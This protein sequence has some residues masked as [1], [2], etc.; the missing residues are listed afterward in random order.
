MSQSEMK[1]A[2]VRRPRVS[3]LFFG[4]VAVVAVASRAPAKVPGE[5]GTPEL[6]PAAARPV[7]F[8]GD[9]QPI[10]TAHCYRCHGAKKQK[11]DYR[12]DTEKTA[13]SGGSIGGAI[14]PGNS[15]ES[16][17]IHYVAGIDSVSVP[18]NPK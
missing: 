2:A 14:V 9:V 16:L 10:F 18:R 11:S 5:D 3:S 12:L 4:V 7:D 17:L 6:P 8:V 15:A 1:L 13:L